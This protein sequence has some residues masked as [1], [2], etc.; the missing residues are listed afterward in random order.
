MLQRA[1]T[2]RAEGKFKESYDCLLQAADAGDLEAMYRICADWNFKSET[3][4]YGRKAA[5]NGYY[6]ACVAFELEI[7]IPTTPFEIVFHETRMLLANHHRGIGWID[8]LRP[9]VHTGHDFAQATWVG[10]GCF[11][12]MKLALGHK[13][14]Y[15]CSRLGDWYYDKKEYASACVLLQIAH[16]QGYCDSSYYLYAIYVKKNDFVKAF[17]VAAESNSREFVS[18]IICDNTRIKS[19][20]EQYMIGRWRIK[21]EER[22]VLLA[23]SHK[24]G[25]ASEQF[26]WNNLNCYMR[27]YYTSNK[28]AQ[29]ASRYWMFCAKFLGVCKDVARI[30]GHQIWDSRT[31]PENWLK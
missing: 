20:E 28:R 14:P 30:I 7:P 4:S 2:L 26:F 16:D 5:K 19:L 15:V 8:P 1:L 25:Y 21:V 3:L 29:D 10:N 9:F 27:V 31:D 23:I 6:L 18:N 11:F 24:S 13:N 12:D 17:E 22:G